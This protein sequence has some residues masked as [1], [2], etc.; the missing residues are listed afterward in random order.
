MKT[1]QNLPHLSNNI[2][3]NCCNKKTDTTN[4]Y[5]NFSSLR[6]DFVLCDMIMKTEQNFLNLF[7]IYQSE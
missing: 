2:V 7:W 6:V 4:V 3:L 1:E 5:Q